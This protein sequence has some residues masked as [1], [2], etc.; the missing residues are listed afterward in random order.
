MTVLRRSVEIA[1]P[2]SPIGGSVSL[3]KLGF[4]WPVLELLASLKFMWD[5]RLPKT[6]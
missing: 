2:N 1:T 5:I 6:E 3:I 4:A